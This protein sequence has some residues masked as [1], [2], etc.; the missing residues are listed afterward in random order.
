[1][2]RLNISQTDSRVRDIGF[3]KEFNWGAFFLTWIWAI[4]NKTFNK[5]TLLLLILCAVPY[6]GPLSAIG[7]MLYSGLTGNE[8][9][10][11]SKDWHDPE[12]FKKVQR[13]W[14]FVGVAQFVV[15]LLFVISVP[16]FTTK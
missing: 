1:M 9:A 15:A 10:W 7:L 11:K 12:H 6:V 14:A 13:R 16:L 5:L 2:Q 8:R 4:G 3:P